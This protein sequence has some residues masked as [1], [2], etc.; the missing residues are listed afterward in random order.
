MPD[1][2]GLGTQRLRTHDRVPP[3]DVLNED[4]QYRRLGLGGSYAGLEPRDH[5]QRL[6]RRVN[7]DIGRSIY[8]ESVEPRRRN[9]DDRVDL[10]SDCQRS[11]DDVVSTPE[12]CAPPA[13]ADNGDVI[14]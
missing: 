8:F 7:P 5:H 10:A 12:S 11:S 13:G 6:G 1:T 2:E 4:R 9:A 14:V 3:R